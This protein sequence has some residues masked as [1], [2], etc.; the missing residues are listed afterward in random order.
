VNMNK[1]KWLN[2]EFE[3]ARQ[4]A[5]WADIGGVY[6]F[7]GVNAQNQ[8]VALYIG[9]ADSFRNRIPQHEQW[10][11]AAQLG[12]THVHA[13]VVSQGA[14]RDWIERQMVQTYQPPL[15]VQHK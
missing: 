6:V 2:Y 9:Q 8:W 11:P 14:T 7:A 4:W 5:N 10:N 15:N 13:L 3:V 1:V 12:A